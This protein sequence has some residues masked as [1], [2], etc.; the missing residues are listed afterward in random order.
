MWFLEATIIFSYLP[1]CRTFGSPW[2]ISLNGNSEFIYD[3][4]HIIV[5]QVERVCNSRTISPLITRFRQF[6]DLVNGIS[7]IHWYQFHSD[8]FNRRFYSLISA[9][10][11]LV[12]ERNWIVEKS[13]LILLVRMT[14]VLINYGVLSETVLLFEH[15]WFKC[16]RGIELPDK[17]SVFAPNNVFY[18]TVIIEISN[19]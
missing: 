9:V 12:C 4:F 13:P 16:I 6:L 18:I 5:I 2:S 14:S 15:V 11:V 8:L 3:E 1:I 17:A 7:Q 19:N 10:L